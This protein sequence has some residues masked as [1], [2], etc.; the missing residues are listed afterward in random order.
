M[1]SEGVSSFAAAIAPRGDG[2][3]GTYSNVCSLFVVQPLSPWL[4]CHF[5]ILFF[6][7]TLLGFSALESV[8]VIYTPLLKNILLMIDIGRE[9]KRRQEK[10]TRNR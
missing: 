8:I 2:F 3:S 10:D 9:T 5:F 1:G 6:A 7:L 4:P